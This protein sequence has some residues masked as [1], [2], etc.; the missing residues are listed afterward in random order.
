MATV[1]GLYHTLYM[2]ADLT[3]GPCMSALTELQQKF[4]LALCA[5]PFGRQIQW[6][7]SAGY[8]ESS[9]GIVASK[10]VRDPK[11]QLAVR[12]VTLASANI[13][14]P[15]IGF[16][17]LMDVAT[18]EEHKDRVKAAQILLDRVGMG[19]VQKIDVTHHDLT[20]DALV[21]RIREL[22][23]RLGLDE[24][25]LLGSNAIDGEYEVVQSGAVSSGAEPTGQF[26]ESGRLLSEGRATPDGEGAGSD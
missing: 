24:Q 11:I 17:T 10:L 9:A 3:G 5:N 20:G 22:G 13:M 8:A 6:A 26:G 23:Q 25:K 12:E 19:A 15:P 4:V 7:V 14:G 16:K 1:L 2:A 21:A 18:N